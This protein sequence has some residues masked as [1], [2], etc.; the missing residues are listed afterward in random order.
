M[1]RVR[2]NRKGASWRAGRVPNVQVRGDDHGLWSV[3]RVMDQSEQELGCSLP[4]VVLRHSHGGERRREAIRE[5]HV[6]EPTTETS[7]GHWRPRAAAASRTLSAIRSLLATIAVGGAAESNSSAAARNPAASSKASLSTVTTLGRPSR[8]VTWWKV[9]FRRAVADMSSLLPTYAIRWCPRPTRCVTANVIPWR[10]S[11]MTA[12]LEASPR[13][14]ARFT[15]VSGA[16]LH[17]NSSTSSPRAA[18]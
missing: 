4:Q 16:P 14:A 18:P 13:S 6:V 5:R 3:R 12:G 2:R 10:S 15:S 11:D 17:R 9:A 1:A 7:C 8:R